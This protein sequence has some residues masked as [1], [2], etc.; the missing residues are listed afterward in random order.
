MDKVIDLFRSQS[1]ELKDIRDE[2]AKTHKDLDD[3]NDEIPSTLVMK[4]RDEPRESHVLQRGNFL[5]PADR[6]Y[7][8]VPAILPPLPAGQPTNR[9]ALARWLVSPEN[10]LTARVTMNRFW[11]Q[12]FGRGIVETVEDFGTQG[13][14]PTHPELLDWLATEFVW[15]NWDVKAMLRL[16]VTSATYR[17]SSH[18]DANL[19]ERDPYNRLYARGPR[20]RVS[21]ESVRDIA[22][23]ASGLLSPKI[24][25][26][27]VF[28]YQP[29]G[30]WTQIYSSR[31]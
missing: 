27:S 15:E 7:P 25:G 17:Q 28:P 22:L 10:P 11:E 30:I 4:E 26:P 14:R 31:T 5:S 19:I 16:L 12:I 29:D 13:E 1:P 18:S 21:A 23:S 6:V 8:G 24:G 3:L 9:V 2:L 20:Y